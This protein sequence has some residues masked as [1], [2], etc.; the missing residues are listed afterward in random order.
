MLLSL[1]NTAAKCFFLV[2]GLSPLVITLDFHLSR[3]D[4][5]F[6]S[7]CCHIFVGRKWLNGF[8]IKAMWVDNWLCIFKYSL[9][10]ETIVYYEKMSIEIL[11][12]VKKF[13]KLIKGV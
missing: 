7:F 1:G 6:N 3:V 11:F 12:D 8:K 10:F 2:L 13:K 9:S 5:F 4:C